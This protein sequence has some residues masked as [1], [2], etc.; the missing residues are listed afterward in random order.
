MKIK[1]IVLTLTW[2]PESNAGYID[3]G[4]RG[5][6]QAVARTI[7]ILDQ[8]SHLYGAIDLADNG[9]LLGIELLGVSEL[10]PT[11]SR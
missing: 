5:P 2:D 10:L 9:T 3:T 8:N 4:E 11:T 1:Q 7:P 6:G